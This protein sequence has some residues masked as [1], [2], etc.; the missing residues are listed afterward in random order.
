M[1]DGD[2]ALI[3]AAFKGHVDVTKLL[4]EKGADLHKQGNVSGD[5]CYHVCC[6]ACGCE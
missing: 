2:T 5:A 3:K 6:M 1:Q 4:L